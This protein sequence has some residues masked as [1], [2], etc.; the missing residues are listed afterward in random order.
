VANSA[1]NVKKISSS[2]PYDI[3]RLLLSVLD[4]NLGTRNPDT[5]ESG[6]LGYEI[7]AQTMLTS[8]VLHNLNM[9]WNEAFT[10]LLVLPSSLQNHANMF[11]YQL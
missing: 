11:D 1:E 9:A 3:K 6:Y 8:D 10:H 7:Q 2:D 4:K 5:Y